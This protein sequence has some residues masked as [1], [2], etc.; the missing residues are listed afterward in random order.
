MSMVYTIQRFFMTQDMRMYDEHNEEPALV[1]TMNLN[2][3]LG[4]VSYVFSDKTGT[5]TSNLMELRKCFVDGVAYGR[6]TTEIGLARMK[7]EGRDT[8]EEEL[9]LEQ[10]VMRPPRYGVDRYVNF[11]DGSE[12]DPNER[13]LTAIQDKG[14][15]GDLLREFARNMA[16]NHTVFLTTGKSPAGETFT[17]LSAS[18]PDEQAFVA[19]ARRFGFELVGRDTDEGTVTVREPDGER[20]YIIAEVLEY[21][22]Y[23]KRMSVIVR[24]DTGIKLYCKGA[25]SIIFERLREDTDKDALRAMRRQLGEWAEDA[26]RTLVFAS[27]DLTEE[28]FEA[29]RRRFVEA[30]NDPEQR[31]LRKAGKPN[32]IDALMDEAETG[33]T[34]Q[35]ATAVEDKLQ[36][37]VPR[38]LS[39]L[40]EAGIKIWMITGDKV[41]TA[42]NIA[43]A[44]SLLGDHM[45]W[46]EVTEDALADTP[47]TEG[48]QPLEELK[49]KKLVDAQ[50]LVDGGDEAG[51]HR[52]LSAL[53][54]EFPA[55]SD[56]RKRLQD[57]RAQMEAREA[58]PRA[59]PGA[60]PELALIIDEKC[61]DFALM[62]CKD[63]LLAVSRRC[64]SV[65][66][67][68][69]RKDQK[70]KLLELVRDGVPGTITLGI[71]DGAND[72]D[73]I[74]AGHIGVGVI[75]KEGMQAVNNSDYAIGQFRFLQHLLLRHGRSNYRRMAKLVCFMFYKNIMLVAA[76][77]LF[78]A[79]SGFS[80]QKIYAEMGLQFYNTAFTALLVIMMAVYDEDVQSRESVPRQEDEEDE[81]EAQDSV[82]SD[83]AATSSG[84]GV[85]A[86]QTAGADEEGG[87][88]G[89]LR[90][91]SPRRASGARAVG[92]DTAPSPVVPSAPA[93]G[94]AGAAGTAS[95][96]KHRAGRPICFP[97][98]FP[99]LY[100]MGME[101]RHLTHGVFWSWQAAAVFNAVLIFYIT[102]LTL[103]GSAGDGSDPGLWEFGAYVM[104]LVTW[105]ANF[106]I[107]L[108]TRK[109][110]WSFLII[111]ILSNLSWLLCATVI[112]LLPTL[113]A[114]FF[115][116]IGHLVSS[117]TFWLV[118]PV[119]C[120]LCL[121][122]D[123]SWKAI[124]REWFPEYYHCVQEVEKLKLPLSRLKRHVAPRPAP[125]SAGEEVRAKGA[126]TPGGGPRADV[127]GEA[128]QPTAVPAHTETLPVQG[129]PLTSGATESEEDV[130]RGPS[131]ASRRL[132]GA[133]S[134][135]RAAR[136]FSGARS[137]TLYD[138]D[139][140]SARIMS[141]FLA[142][143]G[144]S[145][146][147]KPG[148]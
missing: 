97:L 141:S 146:S 23:R 43:V 58:Q 106:K 62:A 50:N 36:V 63:D 137:N 16:V 94:V 34:L 8:T 147:P 57:A 17:E 42:K 68:R 73:M 107:M 83:T 47:L 139:D 1:R 108:E 28:E 71:G 81:D 69:A 56:V 125:P 115:G 112:S 119:G 91:R 133:V 84:F 85:G 35:G 124:R 131:A 122:R 2:D 21:V 118:Q 89:K 37:G 4:Q 101:Q 111:L 88:A 113:E 61:I 87:S 130:R 45:E 31:S 96:G 138:N 14:R 40:G 92:P 48:Q 79:H 64:A 136:W 3:E 44:C 99:E 9:L 86:Q 41:G 18:S 142:G 25:D 60:V 134:A 98:E 15:R 120:A 7:S 123:V 116:V 104:T 39:R 19:S 38:T 148:H 76:Q 59:G 5:L 129:A 10:E 53:E 22:S 49:G 12:S 132:V 135:V 29:W 55:L 54:R 82:S 13:L 143:H 77:F 144:Y 26:L 20:T 32:S 80:G 24:S 51:G 6:G 102:D 114:N 67:C 117:P 46:L 110:H 27:R 70:K 121:F 95:S 33:L 72:V 65:V 52:A 103:A 75:G 66:A 100:R 109:L 93:R 126:V 105:V 74:K 78:Q 145:D 90:G 11:T 127:G 140:S 128:E 30:K